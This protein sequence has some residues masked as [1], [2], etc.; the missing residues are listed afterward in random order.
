VTTG[1]QQGSPSRQAIDRHVLL[2]VCDVLCVKALETMGKWI[3]RVERR[4]YGEAQ[5]TGLPL[6]QAHTRWPVTDD[7]VDKAL[8]GAWDVIPAMLS[9]HGCCGVTAE[10]VT[11]MLDSYVHDLAITGTPH[12]IA[13]LYYRF[14]TA[15]GPPVYVVEWVGH[16][17]AS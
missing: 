9:E 5:L 17:T 1:Q 10:Q 4:R 2:A 12:S 15:L 3:L 13:E 16:G 11:S 14:C 8:R 7:I 6:H